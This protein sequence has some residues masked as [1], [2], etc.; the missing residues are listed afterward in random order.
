MLNEEDEHCDDPTG[1]CTFV[2]LV[3]SAFIQNSA[4]LAGGAV[5]ASNP[6]AFWYHCSA[7]LGKP[8]YHRHDFSSM[9]PV[10]STKE[11]CRA[12]NNSA[13]QFGKFVGSYARRVNFTEQYFGS[14]RTTH[15]NSTTLVIEDHRSG[16]P[17]PAIT[18]T[19]MD[20]FGQGPAF[21]TANKPVEAVMTSEDE[22]LV[23]GQ[24]HANMSGGSATF[25]VEAISLPPGNYSMTI[26]FRKTTALPRIHIFVHFRNCALGERTELENICSACGATAFNFDPESGQCQPCPE[27][28]NCTTNVIHPNPGHWHSDPCSDHIQECLTHEACDYEERQQRLV[29]TSRD[30]HSCEEC[31]ADLLGN[32]SGA[33]CRQAQSRSR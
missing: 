23:S 5:F 25:L 13:V 33:Q 10:N 29:N 20:A 6:N 7:A 17:L 3:R 11:P 30:I 19:V 18:V 16:G 28:G 14:G 1:N 26:F 2:A 15:P 8:P 32:Y 9:R 27:N 12:R 21:R 4:S 24:R 31:D 22:K